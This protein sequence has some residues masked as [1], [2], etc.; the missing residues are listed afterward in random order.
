[1]RLHAKTV[2]SGRPKISRAGQHALQARFLQQN[3]PITD[4]TDAVAFRWRIT[5]DG[6]SPAHIRR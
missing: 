6:P 4:I 5:A 3:R 2:T 1:M